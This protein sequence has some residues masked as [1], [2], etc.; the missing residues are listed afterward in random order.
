MF[1]QANNGF[2]LRPTTPF[3]PHIIFYYRNIGTALQDEIWLL[4]K[5]VMNKYR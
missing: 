5:I 2:C 4:R 3:G 1:E